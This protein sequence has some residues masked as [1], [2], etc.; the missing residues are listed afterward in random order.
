VRLFFFLLVLMPMMTSAELYR[1]RNETGQQVV[2]QQIPAALVKNGYEI[3]SSDGLK[4]LE[5]VPPAL[6][7]EELARARLNEQHIQEMKEREERQKKEDAILLRLY[8]SPEDVIVTR[9]GKLK[10]LD[11]R[12]ES[13]QSRLQSLQAEKEK[14]LV[15]VADIERT[16]GTVTSSATEKLAFYDNRIKK[17]EKAIENLSSE[18]TEMV[19]SFGKEYERMRVLFGLKHEHPSD[20]SGESSGSN[21]LTQQLDKEES[22]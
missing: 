15:T 17:A 12:I 5:V 13:A 3:L 19:L 20:S 22:S 1:Y 14:F 7:E 2:G 8:S 10:E 9:D 16:G 4:V 21:Q 6:T 11:N 18:K